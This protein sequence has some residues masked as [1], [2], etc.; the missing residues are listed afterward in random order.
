VY[1]KDKQGSREM[2]IRQSLGW[3]LFWVACALLFNLGIL[4]SEGKEAAILFF[5]GY[6][7]EK[8][9]SFDNVFV[10][11]LI[12]EAFQIPLKLQHRVLMWGVLGAIVLRFI[13]IILG[14]AL[15][16][17]FYWMNYVFGAILIIT[18]LKML[19]STQS[20]QPLINLCKKI[21]PVTDFRGEAF[22]VRENGKLWM[23][24]LFL[25]LIVVEASD[26]LFAID[27]IPAIFAITNDPFI[28]FTSNIFAI[29]GLRSL[30][31]VLAAAI[32]RF[33]Y[34][35]LSL[36]FLLAFVGVKMCLAHIYPIDPLVSLLIILGILTVGILASIY[37]KID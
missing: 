19:K 36:V 28:V 32:D 25:A 27:S 33:H 10:I 17:A 24:P 6:I 31:F 20:V 15:L 30:Y 18:A 1:N 35:R 29:L 14:A 4:L 37:K 13:M 3:T 5:T 23:T 8:A 26:V 16:Q 21:F 34:M 11:A 7:I 12:F 22:F 9:L 2:T